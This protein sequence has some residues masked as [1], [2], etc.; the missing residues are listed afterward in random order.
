[1]SFGWQS[2]S[3]LLPS[4]AKPINNVDAKSIISLKSLVY[5]NTSYN[6]NNKYHHLHRHEQKINTFTNT[7]NLNSYVSKKTINKT[8][9]KRK[10]D[11]NGDD[12]NHHD[13][14]D[15]DIYDRGDKSNSYKALQTKAMLYDKLKHGE[16][17]NMKSDVLLLVS[18]NSNSN[19][20]NQHDDQNDNHNTY[21]NCNIN[22]D[23]DHVIN[24]YYK[25]NNNNDDD[26]YHQN[27]IAENNLKRLIDENYKKQSLHSN[28]QDFSQQ[29]HCKASAST[30]NSTAT[31]ASLSSVIHFI[32]ATSSNRGSS[33]SSSSSYGIDG[34]NNNEDKDH[35]IQN[36]NYARVKSQWEKTLDGRTKTYFDEIHEETEQYRSKKKEGKDKKI[37]DTYSNV[38]TDTTIDTVLQPLQSSSSSLSSSN[39]RLELTKEERLARIHMKRQENNKK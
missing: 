1:M 35:D 3:A 5:N 16:L 14:D 20:D 27:K 11:N 31:V 12:N 6:D 15:D 33:S 2:E 21:S 37:D 18:N 38:A 39:Y 25:N 17:K 8:T 29:K 30:T 32:P 28:N 24:D 4:K 36:R 22:N 23:N 10:S 13:D 26:D 19:H 7:K 9:K 34:M